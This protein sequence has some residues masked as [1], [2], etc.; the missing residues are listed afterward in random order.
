M[1]GRVNPQPNYRGDD[2]EIAQVARLAR[3][4]DKAAGER[5]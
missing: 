1:V 5:H 2:T 3:E 4:A